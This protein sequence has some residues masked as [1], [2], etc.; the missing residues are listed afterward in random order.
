MLVM[1]AIVGSGPLVAVRNPVCKACVKLH[2]ATACNQV[3]K[4]CLGRRL[5]SGWG[6]GSACCTNL[7]VLAPQIGLGLYLAR[8]MG[9]REKKR[10]KGKRRDC[11]RGKASF[12]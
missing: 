10:R 2:P 5:Q 9:R 3:E 11:A 1:L 12:A 7:E 8:Q 4:Y 6:M